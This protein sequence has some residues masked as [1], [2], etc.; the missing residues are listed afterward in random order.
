MSESDQK[1][2]DGPPPDSGLLTGPLHHSQISARVPESVASGVFSTGAIVIT[3]PSEFIL[4]FVLRLSR[5][6]QVIARVVL[7][8]AVVPQVINAMRENI[9][10]YIE[11]FG[12]MKELP[13]PDNNNRVSIQ[14]IYDDLKI[15]DET[16]S[17]VYANGVMIGHTPTEFAFDFFT[18]FFPHSAVSSRVYL[19]APQVPRL[20]EALTH[21]Y[22]DYLRRMAAAQ[23]QQQ[24][25]QARPPAPIP[26]TASSPAPEAGH[27]P[28]AEG[29]PPASGQ[30]DPENPTPPPAPPVSPA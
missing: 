15:S 22:Q 16:L 20:L 2:P 18:N 8:Q 5:P 25:Q 4:D 14:E 23:A 10:R 6:H 9:A 1:P 3:G 11:Q 28:G 12:P 27:P 21:T 13:K 7:P 17:G 19:S 24:Q 29:G 26:P 30:A